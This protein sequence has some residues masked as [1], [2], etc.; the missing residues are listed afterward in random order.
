MRG[1]F[2]VLALLLLL[3]L[4][5][6]IAGEPL[7][8]WVSEGSTGLAATQARE[9]WASRARADLGLPTDLWDRPVDAETHE[10]VRNVLRFLEDRAADFEARA[11][12]FPDEGYE[13]LAQELRTRAAKLDAM[14]EYRMGDPDLAA[15]ARAY[16]FHEE[17]T[18]T[19]HVFHLTPAFGEPPAFLE[20]T[21]R[22][23][24][25]RNLIQRASWRDRGVREEDVV[26]HA[27]AVREHRLAELAS[28]LLHELTHAEQQDRLQQRG[29]TLITIG[30]YAS[31]EGRAYLAQYRW[32]RVLGDDAYHRLIA[33]EARTGLDLPAFDVLDGTLDHLRAYGVHGAEDLDPKKSIDVVARA[34]VADRLDGELGIP[35]RAAPADLDH[36]V[37]R[38][39]AE[40]CGARPRLPA[41]SEVEEAP[42]L[43][44][45]VDAWERC[46][47]QELWR[48][49]EEDPERAR[50]RE[51]YLANLA[52]FQGAPRRLACRHCGFSGEH[53]WLEDRWS[54]PLCEH[55]LMP[56]DVVP[57]LEGPARLF[58][59]RRMRLFDEARWRVHQDAEA[60]RARLRGTGRPRTPR[61]GD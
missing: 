3:V 48:R 56:S 6:G 18:A 37:T 45:A 43:R 55:C 24:V 60:L 22:E 4:V 17:S 29:S 28:V 19:R 31:T 16:F 47:L 25:R 54:C 41:E 33:S 40:A 20:N 61:S 36:E 10:V 14:V 51:R 59:R 42:A 11:P 39:V 1:T 44:R 34:K 46:T 57:G 21:T 32:L 50:N 26:H 12:F 8:E 30:Q 15:G 53:W 2:Q 49:R 13:V 9:R 5:G 7:V 38:A 23:L 58:A 52:G 27:E 35:V